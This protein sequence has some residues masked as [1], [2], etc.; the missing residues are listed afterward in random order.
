MVKFLIQRPIAVTV[1]LIAFIVM[2]LVAANLIPV[3]LMPAIDI[4]EVMI[5]I[6]VPETSSQEVESA[7]VSRIRRQLLQVSHLNDVES[8]SSNGHGYIRLMF[9]YGTNINFAIIEVNEKID[10]LMHSMPREFHRPRVIKTS[11]TDIPVFYLNVALKDVRETKHFMELSEFCDQVIKK[12]VEQLPEVAM[13]DISGTEFPEIVLEVDL[14]KLQHLGITRQTFSNALKANDYSI[15]SIKVRSGLYEYN[16]R[17]ASLLSNREDIE[18]ITLHVGTRL[19][20]LKEL[21][22][23]KI[24]PQ[25][26]KGMCIANDKRSVVMAVI[27]KSSA[28]MA[29]LKTK[30]ADLVKQLEKDY[31]RLQ[32]SVERNQTELLDYS[33]GN[34]EWGLLT[35]ATLAFLIMFLFLK[36]LKSPV[37]IGL[38][39]PISL[40]I[41][42]LFFFLFHISIN[43]I[44]LSGLILGVGMMIDNSII[45]IDNIA[46]YREKGV[47][48]FKSCIKGTN[49]VIRPLISSVLTTCAVFIP[50]IFIK[51]IAG[52]LF[53]DQ[54]IAVTIGL[55]VSLL[56][57]FT[58][59]PVYF[60]LFYKRSKH[61]KSTVLQK[62][63]IYNHIEQSYAKGFDLVFRFKKLFIAA[64]L[65]LILLGVVGYQNIR[66]EKFPSFEEREAVITLDWNKNISIDENRRRIDT[67]FQQQDTLLQETSCMIGEQ[68]FV[69]DNTN[70]QGTAQAKI[71]L[72]ASSTGNLDKVLE[73]FYYYQKK[74][75]PEAIVQYSAPETIFEKVFG[76]EHADLEIHL[77]SNKDMLPDPDDVKKLSE[78]VAE[79]T[80]LK[81]QNK[82]PLQQYYA[83]KPVYSLLQLYKVNVDELVAVLQRAFNRYQLFT[84]KQGQYQVPVFL[85]G[86]EKSLY[87]IIASLKVRSTNKVDVPVSAMVKI[88]RKQDYKDFIGDKNSTYINLDYDVEQEDAQ[89]VIA[90]FKTQ[91]PAFP[92]MKMDIGGSIV[93]N[94]TLFMQLMVILLVSVLLLY[95]ILAAQFESLLQP[96][97]VLIEIP[98]DIAGAILVLWLTGNS[99]NL[100]A[101]IGII[102]MTGIIINDSILKID[103]INRLVKS[104]YSV[105]EAIHLGGQRRLKPIIMTSLTTIL[106]MVPFLFG[107]D[108]GS[109]LQQ[110]LALSIIGGM[111]IGTL[112][113]LYFIP[114]CYYLI[115]LTGKKFNK[116]KTR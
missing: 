69:L 115:D 70:K 106:A 3:S 16:V 68:D 87:Q 85:S 43:V 99:L 86:S 15:G 55:G 73:Q 48:V 94:R 34:L 26:G 49:E 103:T 95:F 71:Y 38:S 54:A 81:H 116:L 25:Q 96:L 114:L 58:I 47:S 11:A 50:L 110:P 8:H 108:M 97:I 74:N 88:E 51:G 107:Q 29:D 44:S 27:K 52:S 57:S 89:D 18:D 17:Y 7:Y 14:E 36:D 66:K 76:D 64:S 111:T 67:F 98:I 37:L 72:K 65:L 28:R 92:D 23:I 62:I 5:K 84:L 112:V 21:A 75:Y 2:S 79:I 12:R 9:N 13:A 1:A 61:D 82:Q 35:G 4:P 53:Y 22:A 90:A 31:P 78:K 41:S 63:Q 93:E 113:S 30:T 59:I 20:K 24:R 45:V 60:Y 80:G 100:M 56:V 104:N 109:R 46:Q 32:F 102:V 39:V 42:L 6:D 19:F 10:A 105:L 33:I 101:L 77:S 40:V 91:L 83:I